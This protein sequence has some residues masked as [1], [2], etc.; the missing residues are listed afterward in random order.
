M[1]GSSQWPRSVWTSVLF[2]SLLSTA[3]ARYRLLVLHTNDMHSRFD[4]IDVMGAEC[5]APGPQCYGGFPR[6]KTAVD[7]ERRRAE[8]DTVDGTLF[9]NAGD[10]FQGTAYYSF[11]KWRA[12][13]RMIKTLGI[14]VMVSAR[15]GRRVLQPLFGTPS[16]SVR[17]SPTLHSLFSIFLTHFKILSNIVVH[18]TH[19]RDGFRGNTVTDSRTTV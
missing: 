1:T 3:V 18:V 19:C 17:S 8:S 16:T 12:V 4:Q 13:E 10:T 11:F 6:L 9:L 5:V 2:L 7:R 15:R 14:D